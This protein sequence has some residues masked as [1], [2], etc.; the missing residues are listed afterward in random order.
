MAAVS[1]APLSGKAIKQYAIPNTVSQAWYIGRAVH[2]AHK[3]KE[4]L[5][6]AIV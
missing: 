4:N 3:S 2:K 6:D 1:C 5:I